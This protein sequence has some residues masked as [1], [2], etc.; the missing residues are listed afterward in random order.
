MVEK[1]CIEFDNEIFSVWRKILLVGKKFYFR[2]LI[3]VMIVFFL[4]IFVY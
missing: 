4:I 3:N 2:V 1:L